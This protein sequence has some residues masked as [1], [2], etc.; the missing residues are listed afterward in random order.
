MTTAAKPG[1]WMENYTAQST[2]CHIL[3]GFSLLVATALLTR[4]GWV[5]GAAEGALGAWVV[6]KEFWYDLRFETGETWRSSTVD[7][8]GYAAGNAL[9]WGALFAAHLLGRW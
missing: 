2:G 1:D 3:I 4:L 8:L 7:A 9:A 6:G 5:A